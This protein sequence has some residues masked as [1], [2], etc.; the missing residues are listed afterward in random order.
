VSADLDRLGAERLPDDVRPRPG[1]PAA[2][3]PVLVTGATGFFG[4]RIVAGLLEA[5]AEVHAL[6]RAHDDDEAT[7]RM[8]AALERNGLGDAADA[9]LAVHAGDVSRP[10]LALDSA[11]YRR[12]AGSIGY[13]VHAAAVVNASYPYRT[14]Q[15]TNVGGTVE[16]LRFAA[17]GA[18]KRVHHLSAVAAAGRRGDEPPLTERDALGGPDGL[19]D[20]YA[21]SKWAAE[22]LVDE[23]A[24][25]GLETVTYRLGALAGDT[26][27]GLQNDRDQRWLVLRASIALG[28]APL[29]RSSVG[30]L[31]VDDAARAVVSLVRARGDG[32]RRVHLVG[33]NRVPW[34]TLYSWV[35]RA[36]YAFR[37]VE[38]GR[39]RDRVAGLEDDELAG[40]AAVDLGISAGSRPPLDAA[41]T[42]A[43]LAARGI[44]LRPLDEG[45]LGLYL[46]AA[47]ARGVLPEPLA[48]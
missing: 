32:P 26:R 41:G 15:E 27:T 23:A 1:D 13:V 20:G 9:G 7:A 31:P 44:R 25:R 46:R 19:G 17:T 8:V 35:R 10:R 2:D 11:A 5:G 36:G 45:L 28:E 6:V 24:A 43:L 37:L 30:W 4:T 18:P 16:A 22:R 21:Q 38:P 40:L 3:A 47:A 12:L 39:F 48:A 34:L 42:E 33:T 14:L 29:L